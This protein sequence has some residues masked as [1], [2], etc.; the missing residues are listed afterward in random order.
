[1]SWKELKISEV[2]EEFLCNLDVKPASVNT[3][4]AVITLYIKYLYVNKLAF[5]GVNL[6]DI[7]K[8][9]HSLIENHKPKAVNLYLS[10]LRRFYSWLEISGYYTNVF[11]GIKLSKV[12]NTY[13][14]MP[15]TVEQVG[16]LLSIIDT[17]AITGRRD[18]AIINLMVKTGLRRIEINRMDV[19]DLV[20]LNGKHLLRIQ[21]KGHDY[22]D[23]YKPISVQLFD[24]L[25]DLICSRQVINNNDPMFISSIGTNNTRLSVCRISE[26]I[27]AYLNKIGLVDRMYSAHSLRHTAAVTLLESGYDIHY[28]Q[29]YLGHSS[30]ATTQLYTKLI[31][32]RIQYDDSAIN[33]LEKVFFQTS[34]P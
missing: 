4:R 2:L 19:G 20:E 26:I 32:D 10:V 16:K 12:P 28:V 21:R 25:Q 8:W 24:E 18:H 11:K 9:K 30:T 17:T 15:L 5:D 27:K 3:Y 23:Q 14:R 29:M 31:S 22:K 33:D 7:I 13:R 1:M 6:A 34:P